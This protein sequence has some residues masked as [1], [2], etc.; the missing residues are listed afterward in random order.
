MPLGNGAVV[1][2]AGVVIA[3]MESACVAFP[4]ASD[5]PTVKLEVAG[6]EPLGVPLTAPVE[7]FKDAQ[8][9]RDPAEMLK[10]GTAQPAVATF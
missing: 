1:V 6:V 3:V 9:G 7:D 8:G 2:I 5:T 4:F 10:V